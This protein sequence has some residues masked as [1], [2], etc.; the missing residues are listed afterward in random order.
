MRLPRY[1]SVCEIYEIFA[2]DTTSQ[3]KE[4][5]GHADLHV[6]FLNKAKSEAGECWS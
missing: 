2:M 6:L 1:S 4:I 5:M 3:F